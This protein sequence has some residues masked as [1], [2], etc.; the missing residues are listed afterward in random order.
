ML[1]MHALRR[2]KEIRRKN[3]HLKQAQ[4]AMRKAERASSV[5]VTEKDSLLGGSKGAVQAMDP[6]PYAWCSAPVVF[7]R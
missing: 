1:G 7:A 3:K 2:R 5:T 6:V 4:A